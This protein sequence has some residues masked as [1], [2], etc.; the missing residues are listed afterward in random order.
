MAIQFIKYNDS[1]W[2]IIDQ[3]TGI[4]AD[5]SR[6]ND[7]CMGI[8]KPFYRVDANNQT[9]DTLIRNFQTAK[10]I[11]CKS[12]KTRLANKKKGETK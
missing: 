11:A 12:V 2:L 1:S 6:N 7:Y 4:C 9:I 5:I 3:K 10:S 8:N